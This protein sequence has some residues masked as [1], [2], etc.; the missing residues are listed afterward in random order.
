MSSGKLSDRLA[1]TETLLAKLWEPSA[2][3]P[4]KARASTS[5][6]VMVTNQGNHEN[7]LELAS[8]LQNAELARTIVMWLDPNL[9]PWTLESD[10]HAVCRK[11]GDGLICSEQIGLA[12]GIA[13]LPRVSSVVRTLFAP[14]VAT[15]LVLLELS[16]EK[17]YQG[18]VQSVDQLVV[19]SEVLGLS[20]MFSLAEQFPAHLYDLAW[21]RH[22]PWQDA[23]ASAF[24]DPQLRPA[25][26]S[27]HSVTFRS[28][29]NKDGECV[30]ERLLLGW[31]A[32]RLGW[33]F[34]SRSHAVDPLH[35]NITIHFEPQTTTDWKHGTLLEVEL[36]ANLG[37]VPVNLSIVR[38]AMP[39]SLLSNL[40]AEGHAN[41]TERS[42]LT[43]YNS[44][45][46]LDKALAS[47]ASDKVLRD[48]LNLAKTYAQLEAD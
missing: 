48:A 43:L 44:T 29:Q 38:E 19:D 18:W 5:N 42:L 4:V 45:R 36:Q 40:N 25:V 8:S 16:S 3:G 15:S 28:A 10:V 17:L 12:L 23:L 26:S 11:D 20:R 32:S 24:D 46:Q 1:Q 9:E 34:S 33:K 27:I 2:D 7:M 31:F 14:E 22:W 35:N 30:A 47:R 21:T 13:T 37:E 6:V 41:I 39:V